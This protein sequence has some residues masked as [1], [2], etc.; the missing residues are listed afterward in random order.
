MS[1][2]FVVLYML[3]K[4]FVTLFALRVIELNLVGL[5]VDRVD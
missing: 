3:K 4:F 1:S 5:A 2:V